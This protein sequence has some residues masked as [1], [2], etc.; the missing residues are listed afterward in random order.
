MQPGPIIENGGWHFSFLGGHEKVK[1]KLTA[2]SYQGRRSKLILKILDWIFPGRVKTSIRKNKDIFNKGRVFHT[3][4]LNSSFP[5]YL[6]KNLDLYKTMI[7]NNG[8]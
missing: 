1:E 5:D 7:K 2:Y 3:V 4:P 6:N 8:K